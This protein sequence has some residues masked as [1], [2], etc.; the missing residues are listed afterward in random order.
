M[1]KLILPVFL[2]A[3]CLFANAQAAPPPTADSRQTV[4][5]QEICEASVGLLD[6]LGS[7]GYGKLLGSISYQSNELGLTSWDLHIANTIPLRNFRMR[8]KR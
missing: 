8:K 7:T 4:N 5:P 2:L 6:M 1:K 3:C